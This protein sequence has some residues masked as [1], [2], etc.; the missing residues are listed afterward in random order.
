[1]GQ[2]K[3]KAYLDEKVHWIDHLKAKNWSLP[4][5]QKLSFMLHYPKSP[6]LR[7]HWLLPGKSLTDGLRLIYSDKDTS[8]MASFVNKFRNFV[9]YFD[10]D[11][12]LSGAKWDDVVANPQT[13][14]PKVIS[15]MKASY[16][17]HN[18]S[19]KLPEFYCNLKPP[20]DD[21]GRTTV[22]DNIGSS[23]HL[24]DSEDDSDFVDSD[25]ELEG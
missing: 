19:D 25:Y 2:G 22:S 13:D 6:T 5:L 24:S 8:F 23:D 18:K 16:V 17:Q 11:D 7:V 3:N 12:N 14:L 15:P 20:L 10:H 21:A 1:M 9:L 4:W